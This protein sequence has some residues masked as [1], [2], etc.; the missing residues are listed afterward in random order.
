MLF[1]VAVLRQL[2]INRGQLESIHRAQTS[3]HTSTC[4]INGAG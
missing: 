4:I 3:Y 2:G 1:V